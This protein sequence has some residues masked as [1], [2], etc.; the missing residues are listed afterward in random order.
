MKSNEDRLRLTAF[1][2][3]TL[4]GVLDGETASIHSGVDLERAVACR[5]RGELAML[6]KLAAGQDASWIAE[7]SFEG[8][9]PSTV[10]Q[11]V[12]KYCENAV[13]GRHQSFILRLI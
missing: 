12:L 13:C 8:V 6:E 7:K 4:R 10:C 2:Y 9:D 11:F 1:L 3:Y 5:D